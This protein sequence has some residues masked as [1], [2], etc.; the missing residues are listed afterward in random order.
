MVC[1]IAMECAMDARRKRLLFLE[2]TKDYAKPYEHIV[3]VCKLPGL[4]GC[5]DLNGAL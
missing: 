5:P 1:V 2:F 3:R 4:A